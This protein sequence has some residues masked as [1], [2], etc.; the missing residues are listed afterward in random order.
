MNKQYVEGIQKRK[1]AYLK[2]VVNIAMQFDCS[3]RGSEITSLLFK[4]K[5]YLIH[6]DFYKTPHF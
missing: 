3:L 5:R 4:E 1:K 2:S 6:T